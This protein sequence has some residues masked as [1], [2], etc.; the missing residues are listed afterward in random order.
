MSKDYIKVQGDPV[1]RYLDNAEGMPDIP[2]GTIRNDRLED[3]PAEGRFIE[4][5]FVQNSQCPICKNPL[6]GP[7]AV[8]RARPAG[9][10]QRRSSA[11]YQ[12][13]CGHRFHAGC[14]LD[15]LNQTQTFVTIDANGN[16]TES[17]VP[18]SNIMMHAVSSSEGGITC[19]HPTCN[20][21]CYTG[22]VIMTIEFFIGEERERVPPGHY[23][24]VRQYDTRE[25]TGSDPPSEDACCPISG[26]KRKTKNKI[27]KKKRT[28]KKTKKIK[29]KLNKTKRKNS[30]K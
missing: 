30:K 29:K 20:K 1:A 15:H 17:R 18:I 10:V 16:Q 2:I 5:I 25:Y 28:K 11:I 8:S 3:C 13:G 19:P 9:N 26:G 23:D 6:A 4:K 22:D 14:L 27:K 12:L 7:Y 21:I 24:N